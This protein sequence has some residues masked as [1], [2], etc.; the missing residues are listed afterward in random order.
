MRGLSVLVV[1]G[2]DVAFG[3][4]SRSTRLIHGGVRYLE[5]GQIGLVYEAL[6][7]R[8]RLYTSVPHLVKPARFLFPAYSGDRLAPWKLRAG[9]ALYDLLSLYRAKAHNHLGPDATLA[10]EP[11]LTADGLLGAVQYEDAVTDDARLTLAVLQSALRHGAS[12][13]THARVARV[14]KEGDTG[15]A[16]HLEGGAVA[17]GRTVLLATG[18][19]TGRKLLGEPGGDLLSLSKGIHLVVRHEDAPV[20]APVVVQVRGQRRILFVVPWGA[21]TYLGTTDTS[22]EGDPGR[23]GISADDEAEVLDLVGRV[24]GGATLHPD[25]VLSGW[26]GVRPLVRA[27]ARARPGGTVELARTHRI[28]ENADGVMALVGGKL[29]TYR[30]MAE[31]A[32]DRVVRRL[33]IE[34]GRCTTATGSV[35]E[36]RA[37]DAAEL[38]SD[39]LLA[40]LAPRHG[41]HARDLVVRCRE[42]PELAERLANDLPYRWV[43]VHEAVDHEGALHLDDLLRRR[44]PLALTDVHRGGAVAQ[45]VAEVL[46][47]ARGGDASDVRAEVERY[48][49]VVRTET[50]RPPTTT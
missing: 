27:R 3:T 6:R 19:W 40:D 10:A 39:P 46:V 42:R 33:G 16:V 50:G 48:A 35:V 17:R 21:R 24:L 14:S 32:V 7:E 28:V 26:S 1:E 30:A 8:A 37:L 22:F 29:T 47:D 18:P 34:A 43:E 36:G 5:Q 9:L 25:R 31:Q 4:S 38:S 49:E 41:P 2:A 44:L 11:M 15:Y 45:R 12:A 23:S 13:L 20:R